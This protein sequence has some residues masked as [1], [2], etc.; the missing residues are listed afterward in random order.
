M[1]S[2]KKT[3]IKELANHN[4]SKTL[5]MIQICMMNRKKNKNK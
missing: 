2:E 3:I 1:M 5:F 4:F